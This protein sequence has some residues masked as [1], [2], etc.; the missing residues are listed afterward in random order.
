MNLGASQIDEVTECE[1]ECL[2]DSEVREGKALP[3]RFNVTNNVQGSTYLIQRKTVHH[4]HI[5]RFVNGGDSHIDLVTYNKIFH[6]VAKDDVEKFIMVKSIGPSKF[7]QAA[8]PFMLRNGTSCTR[9]A[10][11]GR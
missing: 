1:L 5:V 11:G 6:E 4:K 8:I 2:K 3:E 10:E 7:L 9:G